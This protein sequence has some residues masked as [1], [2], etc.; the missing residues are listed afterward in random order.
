MLRINQH[1]T[2]QR[3]AIDY[4]QYLKDIAP[5]NTGNLAD[6]LQFDVELTPDDPQVSIDGAN[7]AK[8]LDMGVNGTEV[9]HNSIF[10]F[11]GKMPPIASVEDYANSIGASPWAIAKTIQKK[12]ITP[13]M[14]ISNEV[15]NKIDRLADD[16]IDAVWQD[17]KQDN[18]NPN[19][20]R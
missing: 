14:F 15:E 8:Y 20:R 7:Y 12:G 5:K 16:Y 4:T 3:F 10:S 13:T 1:Q 18:K 2:L 19:T 9:N 6:S 17:F 11:G